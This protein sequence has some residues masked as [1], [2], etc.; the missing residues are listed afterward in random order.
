[1][2]VIMKKLFI[3]LFIALGFVRADAA[4]VL[5][6]MPVTTQSSDISVK[7]TV[8]GELKIVNKAN[9]CGYHALFNAARFAREWAKY[10]PTMDLAARIDA[11]GHRVFA[12]EENLEPA[13]SLNAVIEAWGKRIQPRQGL[14]CLATDPEY[15]GDI[16]EEEISRI[17]QAVGV[18]ESPDSLKN[19]CAAGIL[20]VFG[21]FTDFEYSMSEWFSFERM[22]K[23]MQVLQAGIPVGFCICLDEEQEVFGA[24]G[25]VSHIGGGAGVQHWV[26]LG[27]QKMGEDVHVFMMDSLGNHFTPELQ[28]RI[29]AIVTEMIVNDPVRFTIQRA[30]ASYC[31]QL[32]WAVVT[33]GGNVTVSAAG[34]PTITAMGAVD[35]SSAESEEFEA[36]IQLKFENALGELL[37]Q[38]PGSE[39]LISE[40]LDT[41]IMK[42]RELGTV[43]Q[44]H[45]DKVVEYLGLYVSTL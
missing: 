17:I 16:S 19:R 5:H 11:F 4:V 18:K 12:T 27:L 36:L 31:E 37:A 2:G 28:T 41:E 14:A 8:S 23:S 7:K 24:A 35:Y 32:V 39:G 30:L 34:V 26:A 40:I 3:A 33:K 10:A 43:S 6:T 29:Q 20:S 45:A 13:Q 21:S 1:M 9:R 42:P 15:L 44:A 38:F 25:T 22:G